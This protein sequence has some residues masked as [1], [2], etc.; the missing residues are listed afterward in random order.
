MTGVSPGRRVFA[1]MMFDWAS[2]PFYTLCLTFIFGPYMAAVATT[3]FMAQ[4]QPEAM[5]D[6]N[7]QSLWSL[8]Q[9]L[10]GLVIA[11]TAPV[12]GA[13]ADNSGRPMRWVAGFSALYVA[14]A[15]G[16]WG[17][18][19]DGS[20]LTLALLSFAVAMIGVEYATIFTNAMLPGLA[21]TRTIG[22]ISGSG[23]ALGYA[24]GVV[25]LFVMLLFLAEGENGTTLV[26]LRP[27]FGLD[28]ALREGTRAV[29]PFSAIWYLAF[30]LPFFLWIR[31][32][33]RKKTPGKTPG[34]IGLALSDCTAALKGLGRAAQPCG[35]SGCVDAVPGCAG[36]AVRVWR[37]LCHAGA[38]LVGDQ[39]RGVRHHRRAV[40]HGRHLGRGTR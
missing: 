38:E 21:D 12:L 32:P 10:T 28:P 34:G 1:W 25:A 7:A 29:G 22:K 33:A 36:G 20:G 27:A 35:L 30:M 39:R 14:G 24:G 23:F 40:G 16:L 6:A 8:V 2:Q 4:G 11:F 9:T 26:G 15:W 13:M 37:G 3:A 5:A 19:P 31:L 18:M 17:L